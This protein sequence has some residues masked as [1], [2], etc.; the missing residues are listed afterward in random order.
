MDRSGLGPGATV[1][2]R[3]AAQNEFPITV[4][5]LGPVRNPGRYEISRKID[6]INLFA[7]A[8]GWLE[9]ADLSDVH[10]SR[11]RVIG[12]QSDRFDIKLDLEDLTNLSQTFVQLQDGDCV[13]VGTSG[14]I[15]LPIILSVVSSTAA[16]ATA[17]F[18]ITQLN[19]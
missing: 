5:L 14:G 2:Y 9:T 18:Y 13:Y 1:N 4:T 8:G 17:I 19:R 12:T 3:F 7:L 16:V 10:I 15:D 6:L 11:S